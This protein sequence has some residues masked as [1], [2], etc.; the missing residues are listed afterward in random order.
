MKG[1]VTRLLPNKGYGFIRAEDG[2][3]HFFHAKDMV[4]VRD[5]D[6]LREG[7]SVE[8]LSVETDKGLR[9]GRVTMC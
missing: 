3:S 1:T 7:Q 2:Q 5:F 6:T 8:F 9:A 4:K